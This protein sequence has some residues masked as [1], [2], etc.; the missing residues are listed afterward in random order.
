MRNQG[1]I[2]NSVTVKGVGLHSGNPVVVTLLPSEVNTGVVFARTDLPGRP[3]VPFTRHSTGQRERQTTIVG[4]DQAEVQT[5][6]H[7]VAGLYCLGIDNVRVEVSGPEVPGMDGSG[8]AFAEAIQKA[9]R[10]EQR[11]PRRLFRLDKVL[12]IHHGD[13][14]IVAYPKATPGLRVTYTVHFPELNGAGTQ[15]YS[16]DVTEEGFLKEVAPARTFCLEAEAEMLRT[17]GLGQGASTSNTLVLGKSGPIENAFRFPEELARHKI[18]DL[19]GDLSL[20]GSD[21]QAHIIA[22]RTGHRANREL[23]ELLADRFEELE[24]RGLLQ[25]DTGLDVREILKIIPHRYPFLFIDRVVELTGYQ[26][27][28]GIKCVSI[29]E[30]YFQA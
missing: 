7:L 1:T 10:I 11:S 14:S 30:S 29:N 6:E 23:V 22:H 2:K 28:V 25:V 3:E 13:A 8:L 9:G 15:T 24:N 12:A 18:L 20:V 26:R 5:V 19:L 4:R 27:A 17:K 16:F 21:L